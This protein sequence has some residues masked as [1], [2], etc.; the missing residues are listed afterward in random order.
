MKIK[1]GEERRDP[2]LEEVGNVDA[3]P[4]R[5]LVGE[6]GEIPHG[7]PRL[8]LS[9]VVSA[10]PTPL[11]SSGASRTGSR[12]ATAVG[13]GRDQPEDRQRVPAGGCAIIMAEQRQPADRRADPALGASRSSGAPGPGN[14]CRRSSGDSSSQVSRRRRAPAAW[15]ASRSGVVR[16]SEPDARVSRDRRLRPSGSASRVDPSRSY[17]SGRPASGRRSGVSSGLMRRRHRN[18]CRRRG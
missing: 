7:A 12:S 5:R 9:S 18:P 10:F 1:E 13:S 16:V 11:R 2:E 17:R 6:Q 15:A 8:R 3:S 4:W 14:R